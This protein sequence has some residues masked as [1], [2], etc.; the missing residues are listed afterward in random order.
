MNV[1]LYPQGWKTIQ[2]TVDFLS[3]TG[4]PKKSASYSQV[5]KERSTQSSIPRQN[6]TRESKGNK[7]VGHEEALPPTGSP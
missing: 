3:Q 7:V 2:T 5:S 1:A 4:G 6:G